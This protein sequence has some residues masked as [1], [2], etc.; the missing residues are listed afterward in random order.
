[1]I[2]SEQDIQLTDAYLAGELAPE[3]R[4]LFKA[5][6][7]GD[8]EFRR[9]VENYMLLH[10]D[11]RSLENPGIEHGVKNSAKST[12]GMMRWVAVSV[13]VAAL[14]F[15][16]F[17]DGR[18]EHVKLATE[19]W[20]T[21]PGI[22]FVLSSGEMTPITVAMTAYEQGDFAGTLDVLDGLRNDT[23]TFFSGCAYFELENYPLA[24]QCF[25]KVSQTSTWRNE[26]QFRM[27]LTFLALGD[28]EAA[29]RE[30]ERLVRRYPTLKAKVVEILDSL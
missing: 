7:E 11:V 16:F 2:L 17:G 20:S 13:A 23:S 3:A 29:G 15:V 9:A 24:L 28:K 27:A 10:L 14:M 25:S 1:M 8:H 21:H 30:F 26:A 18:P 6:L 12:M 19:H 22:P 4:T 5:R